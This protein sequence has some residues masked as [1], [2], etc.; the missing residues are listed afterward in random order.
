MRDCFIKTLISEVERNPDII[1]ITGDLGF[2]VLDD[3]I[4]NYPNNFI[5]AG[6]AEQNMTGIAAGLALEGKK[7]FTYSIA[8]FPTMRCFEQI[9]NDVCYHNLDVNIV[10]I[11]GGFSY[12]PLGM[13]HHATEDLAVMRSLPNLKILSP[14]G[15]WETQ[16]ATKA[17]ARSKG[18]GFLRLDKSF[19][20]DYAKA[21]ERFVI[22]K[23]RTLTKGTDCTIIVTGGILQE[24]EAAK[25]FLEDNKIST[26]IVSMH[27]IKPIDKEMIV[28]VAKS[29]N[30]VVTLEEH[31]TYGGLGSAI[32]EVVVD[33]HL[34][35]KQIIRIGLDSGFTTVVGSQKYLRKHYN[36]NSDS[37]VKKIL[38]FF[39]KDK[40]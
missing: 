33:N 21:N 38:N 11:G 7:V 27:T 37:I 14:S 20:N 24:A 29:S 10:S 32:C 35:I 31:T 3:F 40:C 25:I 12:G 6:V 8:N 23:S 9:R 36:M 30:L 18:P 39:E 22:G 13:S 4:K 28:N 5:N 15:L 19:G 26:K 34:P 16:E 1:L 17:L 2:G